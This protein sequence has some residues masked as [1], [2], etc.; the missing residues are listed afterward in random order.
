[1]LVQFKWEF[2]QS[3]GYFSVDITLWLRL[4][5]GA[6]IIFLMLKGTWNWNAEYL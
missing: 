3:C 6:A 1:M 5:R 2:G 4:F